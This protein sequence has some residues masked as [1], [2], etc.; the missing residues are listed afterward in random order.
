M[1]KII[2]S[3]AAFAALPV[4]VQ[5]EIQNVQMVQA[6]NA[7][8]GVTY[9]VLDAETVKQ[10]GS[11]E[12]VG[13]A[14]TL[15]KGKY[16]VSFDYKNS[17]KKTTVYVY[18]DG[19]NKASKEFDVASDKTTGT[20]DFEVTKASSSV[21]I[22]A[23]S[24][25]SS[26]KSDISNVTIELQYDFSAV[27]TELTNKI[28]LLINKI[29]SYTYP[30]KDAD[31]EAAG[32]LA[33]QLSEIATYENYK[34]YG[35]NDSWA[36]YPL[37][38]AIDDLDKS[39]AAKETEYQANK[40]NDDAWGALNTNYEAAV[41][42]YN[43]AETAVNAVVADNN[44]KQ[45]LT[46][47]LAGIKTELDNYKAAIDAAKAEGKAT[48]YDTDGTI[49]TAINEKIAA[50][51]TAVTEANSNYTAYNAV[52]TKIAAAQTAYIATSQAIIKSL[53][54][55]A[56]YLLAGAQEKL[57]EMAVKI[58]EATT[59][60]D[61][62]YAAVT[63]HTDQATNEAKIPTTEAINAIGTEWIAKGDAVKAAYAAV[64][65]KAQTLQDN[66]DDI[67]IVSA[68]QAQFAEQKGEAQAAINAIN[69]TIQD[70]YNTAGMETLNTDADFN[71]AC[72][73][74]QTLIDAL[75]TAVDAASVEYNADA[76]TTTALNNL[77]T[78]L[79][80]AKN[81]VEEK[82]SKDGNYKP[83]DKYYK[84]Y[85]DSVTQMINYVDQKRAKAF[86][87]GTAKDFN[88]ALNNDSITTAINAYKINGVNA[89][90][91]YDE[92]TDSITSQRQQLAAAIAAFK[93]LSIYEAPG[94][95]YKSKLDAIDAGL[96]EKEK[97]IDDA[98]ELKNK[99]HWEALLAITKPM[100]Y[101][102]IKGYMDEKDEKQAEYE[103]TAT[104]NALAAIQALV[105]T[106]ITTLNTAINEFEQTN[107][108]NDYADPEN[109]PLGLRTQ[110]I[111]DSINNVIKPQKEAIEAAINAITGT[112]LQKLAELNK[113]SKA[114]DA[115]NKK[116]AK[117]QEQAA[118]IRAAVT[119]NEAAKTEADAGITALN[120]K[121]TDEVDKLPQRRSAGVNISDTY[122]TEAKAEGK[123][124][125]ETH[126]IYKDYA[127]E[128]QAVADSISHLTDSIAKYYGLEQLK[129]QWESTLKAQVTDPNG[130]KKVMEAMNTKANTE[131]DNWNQYKN[132]MVGNNKPY[133]T[134]YDT[135]YT[136]TG[137]LTE[138][139]TGPGALAY[140]TDL[141]AS[142]KDERLEIF[143]GIWTSV[144]GVTFA[145][146]KRT[147]EGKVEALQAKVNT[148]LQD[149][150][151]NK[152]AY[153]DQTALLATAQQ[154]WNDVYFAI[155]A[156]DASTTRDEYLAELNA[157]Q[158]S[159]N[160]A[161]EKLEENYTTGK[162][163][164]DDQ[165][166]DINKMIADINDVKARQNEGYNQ[167]I[168]VDNDA[169]YETNMLA[170]ETLQN[171]YKEA[172]KCRADNSGS[173]EE[174]RE[175]INNHATAFD[176]VLYEM[177]AKITELKKEMGE[178]YGA[179]VSPNLFDKDGSYFQQIND[180]QAEIT[181]EQGD[182]IR[183]IKGVIT[184]WWNGAN[185]KPAY[186]DAVA[187]AMT[188][189]GT[190]SET[191]QEDAFKDVVDLI[192]QGNAA[193][194]EPNL[195]EVEAVVFVLDNGI[196]DMITV[197]KNEAANKDITERLTKADKDYTDAKTE[198]EQASDEISVKAQSLEDL[199]TSYEN[200]IPDAKAATDAAYEAVTLPNNRDNIKDKI[201][202]FNT[203]KE[204]ALNAVRNAIALDNANTEAYDK[205]MDT[206]GI[207]RDTL[208]MAI[209]LNNK[210]KYASVQ[211]LNFNHQKEVLDGYEKNAANYKANGRAVRMLT[212]IQRNANRVKNSTKLIICEA[213]VGNKG[214]LQNDLDSIRAQYYLFAADF[215][216]AEQAAA[217]KEELEQLSD[218]LMKCVILNAAEYNDFKPIFA[219]T[220][221]LL[222]IQDKIAD[223]RARLTAENDE[224]QNARL[225][226]GFNERIA[227][228]EQKATLE[229]KADW[230]K[231]Q[232]VDDQ[233]TIEDAMKE[234]QEEIAALK[235]DIDAHKGEMAFYK[236]KYEL[237]IVALEAA[238]ETLN[239]VVDTYQAKWDANEAAYAR[240]SA[241][242]EVLEGKR[243]D[244]IN[245]VKGYEY[246]GTLDVENNNDIKNAKRLIDYN[247]ESLKDDYDNVWL[248]Q[249][250]E[251]TNKETI[252][253]QIQWF[254]DTQARLD[255]RNITMGENGLLSDLNEVYNSYIQSQSDYPDNVRKNLT[256]QY[257]AIKDEIQAIYLDNEESW[258]EDN[259]ETPA[260]LRTSDADHAGYVARIDAVRERIS[261][262]KEDV[263]TQ[264]LGDLS[265]DGNINTLDYT[266][267]V[268]IIIGK[269]E[270]PAE[271][272]PEFAAADINGDGFINVIDAT[273]LVNIIL[274]GNPEGNTGYARSED[275]SDQPATTSNEPVPTQELSTAGE[276]LGLEVVNTSGKM[277]RLALTL[278]NVN[279]Y[280][281]LQMDVV[282]PEGM[283]LNSIG[284]A[285][286][287]E[288]HDLNYNEVNGATRILLMG[289]NNAAFAGRDGAV[290]YLDVEVGNGYADGSIELNDIVLTDAM[291]NYGLFSNVDSST[292]GI[293]IA[294]ADESL[295]GKIYNLG[296]RVMNG[297]KKG[298]NIILNS[299]GTTKKVSK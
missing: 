247:K 176:Q 287:A 290:I 78:D 208:N 293:S 250:S 168:K 177:P 4:G 8:D 41:S 286:R 103:A 122:S 210:Y 156:T 154:T 170:I 235:A 253:S 219:K 214:Y 66:L 222:A 192:A 94:Y 1:R 166:V 260:K 254:L 179:T 97:A 108:I 264:K 26:N 12:A 70:N 232:I 126:T 252:E 49:L 153:D 29:N 95:D 167:Q 105:S 79:Q 261:T 74:A 129:A 119:A 203:V 120:T 155:A 64:K 217:Y 289:A 89:L 37:Y 131:Y 116:F 134:L 188:A 84:E 34:E 149:A 231:Q 135:M 130:L 195:G 80:N 28:T 110:A 5:A 265:H 283:K 9:T 6:A 143:K 13:D 237:Q 62:S 15:V 174:L 33:A 125:S 213:F 236:E 117:L 128:K 277:T 212:N 75:K 68:L 275:G 101:E 272:T 242:I 251:L 268:N 271:G 47:T 256:A 295:S 172:A 258:R 266:Q 150:K 83:G 204:N 267:I 63:A 40:A 282:L 45:T 297:L 228:L 58:Q 165:T 223:L 207:V 273:Q 57:T 14:V 100:Y 16:T 240:L 109:K 107:K 92:V 91:N 72:T 209:E 269:N 140:Y 215:D 202:A 288:N 159:I 216:K 54:D 102:E 244:A 299:D 114:I 118:E 52:K 50:L 2:Y 229:A 124:T 263:E 206:L 291:G 35:L 274:T 187:A 148:V 81:A 3:A 241:E 280:S 17:S 69:K 239:S 259:T 197:D 193:A 127:A 278:Q 145:N 162:A 255:I 200:N 233:E 51:K 181:T 144:T 161:T 133:K 123:I 138:T 183:D 226:A 121:M 56:Q 55:E 24:A 36:S 11:R 53:V 96:T 113:Q 76:A 224:T 20:L 198:I 22:Q 25:S 158:E 99:A 152:K 218:T 191:A 65:E 136:L 85:T 243:T 77:K 104:S 157:I 186:E 163:A 248:N 281:N 194:A 82:T 111:T 19:S 38:Q 178:A 132:N 87:E 238:L 73:A 106:K 164:T 42:Q 257:G 279:D 112:E 71:E 171:V 44:Q 146:D 211:A 225:L 31:L 221:E 139:V 18:I 230:V 115:L 246:A 67:T 142:Y 23:K 294:K 220:N 262:F 10:V 27:T 169:R 205:M 285:E 90:T 86:E 173:N 189:I 32:A 199:N 60:N 43:E 270:T 48:E 93:D 298:I 234:L 98:L 147:H 227:A 185:R 151:D 175:A 196:E 46:A 160:N 201:D 88:D 7:W 184:D 284:L 276:Q 292:T 61:N 59:A 141:L 245:K 190:Y 30:D 249:E 296:G 137:Q 39:T 21:Q 182:F 180:M